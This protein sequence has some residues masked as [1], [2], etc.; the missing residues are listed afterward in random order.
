M[1]QLLCYLKFLL[2]TDSVDVVTQ[3]VGVQRI[4]IVND[5]S[6]LPP[7]EEPLPDEGWT[8]IY[9]Y[10]TIPLCVSTVHCA[11]LIPLL[12]TLS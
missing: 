8:G 11:D 9:I 5:G 6:E 3:N 4:C 2:Q 12:L 10:N 7:V 1:L